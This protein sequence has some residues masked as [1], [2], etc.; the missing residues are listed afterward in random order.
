MAQLPDL[1][2]REQI[3][4]DLID[5]FLARVKDIDDLNKGSITLQ[6]FEAISFS[7]FKAAANII[8]MID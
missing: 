2:S 1:R 4:G 3:L 5:S 8:S 6:F 7:N